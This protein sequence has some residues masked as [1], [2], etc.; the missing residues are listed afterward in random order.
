[1]Q[2][3]FRVFSVVRGYLLNRYFKPGG[4][5]LIFPIQNDEQP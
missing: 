5:K 2:N 4:L 3:T 1:M